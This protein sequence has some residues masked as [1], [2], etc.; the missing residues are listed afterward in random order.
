MLQAPLLGRLG[1]QL[2][3]YAAMR[4]LSLEMGVPFVLTE[5]HMSRFHTKNCMDCFIL[6]RNASFSK[7][8]NLSLRQQ[9]GKLFYQLMIRKK[10]INKVADMERKCQRMFLLFNS[11]FCQEGYMRP[12]VGNIHNLYAF[13]YFQSPLYFVKH[14]EVIKRELQFKPEAILRVRDCGMKIRNQKSVCLHIRRGDY[15]NDP[16]F[17]VCD[18]DYYYRAIDK[19]RFLVP[20]AHYYV[21]SD[22]IEE[23][24]GLF[25]K[26]SDLHFTYI[27]AKYTDQ[28]SLFLGSCC[29]HFIIS[30]STFSWWMQY[31]S[32]NKSKIVLAPNKWYNT[33]NPCDIYQDNWLLVEV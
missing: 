31:L 13:G 19:M 23:V 14:E 1:N 24:K 25:A 15:L 12:I 28:E 16:V 6:T 20:D 29:R 7:I 18:T 5:E 27:E 2:F 4:S 32:D 21:F 8:P 33:N 9:L 22:N 11:F 30:N 3:I 26:F 10:D 17:N